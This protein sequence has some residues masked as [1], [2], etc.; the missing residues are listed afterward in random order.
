[1]A[2][3]SS[4]PAAP[5]PTT[6]MRGALPSRSRKN[7]DSQ[8]VTKRSIGLTGCACSSTPA[9]PKRPGV[10][11]LSIEIASPARSEPSSQNTSRRCGSSATARV[12][13]QFAPQARASGARST[14]PCS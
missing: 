14:Q 9:T 6:A 8:P 11:P 5:A 13:R 2:M 12:S 3:I 4:Q 1:M 10:D 7:S